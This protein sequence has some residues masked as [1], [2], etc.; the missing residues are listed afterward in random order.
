M[1]VDPI[2]LAVLQG[3]LE[4]VVDEMDVRLIRGAISPIISEAKDMATGIFDAKTGEMISQGR[5][6]L[7]VFLAQMQFTVQLCM[8]EAEKRGGMTPGDVW[9]TN[10]VYDGGTHLNDVQFVKPFFHDGK[11]ECLLAC[12]GHLQDIGGSTA[13]GWSPH[14]QDIHEEGIQIPPIL[15]YSKGELNRPVQDVFCRNVRLADDMLGDVT[16]MLSSL[17]EGEKRLT[18][19]FNRYGSGTIQSCI[20]ELT[21]RSEQLVRKYVSD[22]PD[23]VYEFT[24][25]LDNDGVSDTPI[26]VQVTLKVQ[27]DEMEVDF[28]G[29]SP[30]P[31]GPTNLSANTAIAACYIGLKHIF[32]DVPINGGTFRPFKFH[33]PEGSCLNARNPKPVSGYLEMVGR[34]IEVIWGALAQ[35]IPDQVNAACLG[36]SAILTVSGNHPESNKFFAATYPYPGGYGA[37]KRGDG[38]MNGPTP[39]SMARSPGIETSE[40][41]FPLR[42]YRWS[43]RPDSGGAGQYRGGCGTRYAFKVLADD[44][45]VTIMADRV[46]HTP[47]GISG[48]RNGGPNEFQLIRNGEAWAPPLKSKAGKVRLNF[49]DSVELGSPGGGGYGPPELRNWAAIERDLDLGLVTPEAVKE[50]YG[51]G[52]EIRRL[53]GGRAYY[54]VSST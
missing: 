9:M 10:D 1:S 22:V 30:A 43:L 35:V 16:A 25:Y 8:K 19:L 46:D 27:G 47:F 26:R 42:F 3:A 21:V 13:G 39:Q 52:V 37:S 17:R 6:G 31:A 36:T 53:I 7:P 44:C 49:G 45:E 15:F 48:G 54:K 5:F 12:T 20:S 40:H 14:A 50:D 28:S 11:L 34:V 24:D 23:G 41:R 29:T 33:I 38:L 18:E 2:T 51:V 32:V 4:S